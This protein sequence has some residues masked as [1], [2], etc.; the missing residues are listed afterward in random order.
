MLSAKELEEISEFCG[1][2]ITT[3]VFYNKNNQTIPHYGEKTIVVVLQNSVAGL[4]NAEWYKSNCEFVEQLFLQNPAVGEVL[5][6]D[7]DED[8][9]E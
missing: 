8:E 5:Q 6:E 7:E 9:D 3:L 1:P 4:G 2:P